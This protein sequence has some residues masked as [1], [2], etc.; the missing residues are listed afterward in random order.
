MDELSDTTTSHMFPSLAAMSI[1]EVCTS[2]SEKNLASKVGSFLAL[3]LF[4]LICSGWSLSRDDFTCHSKTALSRMS[5]A[6]LT[7]S[8]SDF[9]GWWC[10]S[11]VIALGLG[12][13]NSSPRR[14]CRVRF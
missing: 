7:Y 10:W 13:S 11:A 5:L 8:S 2:F 3:N 1:E 12:V 6:A 14:L 4:P 9:C